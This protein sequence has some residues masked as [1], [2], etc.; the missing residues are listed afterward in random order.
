MAT[1]GVGFATC[2]ICLDEYREPRILPCGHSYCTNCLK[3]FI[4][5]GNFH[6]PECRGDI[7]NRPIDVFPVNYGLVSAISA[8]K[9]VADDKVLFRNNCPTHTLP[10]EFFCR[11]QK[12]SLSICKECWTK[13][14]SHHIVVPV[15]LEEL[16]SK[17]ENPFAKN[18]KVLMS[19]Q[20]SEQDLLSRLTKLSAICDP[21]K[22][23]T[24]DLVEYH[25]EKTVSTDNFSANELL[26]YKHEM[27]GK[28]GRKQQDLEMIKNEIESLRTM[29]LTAEQRLNELVAF[30]GRDS[31]SGQSER[32]SDI[33]IKPKQLEVNTRKLTCV[34]EVIRV[35]GKKL[36]TIAIN[37]L[38][39]FDTAFDQTSQQIFICQD[40]KIQAVD[41]RLRPQIWFKVKADE[42]IGITVS[43]NGTLFASYHIGDL[44]IT[45]AVDKTNGRI[46]R[47]IHSD[48]NSFCGLSTSNNRLAII[49][50]TS[51][52]T[53]QV[54]IF[55]NE[56]FTKTFCLK[57]E[58]IYNFRIISHDF[59]LYWQKIDD[60]IQLVVKNIE[61]LDSE[62]K[63]IHLFGAERRHFHFS[64]WVPKSPNSGYL[65]I[66]FL[67][68]LADEA[69]VFEVDLENV[70]DNAT[71]RPLNIPLII[72]ESDDCIAFLSAV[73]DYSVLCLTRR[74]NSKGELA[75]LKL[76]FESREN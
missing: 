8:S 71:L 73:A 51:R 39:C 62:N 52:S 14:H 24:E 29:T 31:T 37:R 63:I 53:V 50:R 75:L 19:F 49:H 15:E 36:A 48:S 21:L 38:F 76:E 30:I 9:E 64:I 47:N 12:C 7:P 65:F 6:C 58:T 66:S 68:S 25:L 60:R 34:R 43:G 35:D 3:T 13:S 54:F 45:S 27:L 42:L 41:F 67:T 23:K 72:K 74:R 61:N 32:K 44:R 17:I 2:S 70:G 4:A 59:F 56:K 16:Q 33:T 20:S 28:C 57:G 18:T 22:L 1:G 5:G 10:E 55:D 69:M 26:S 46:L 40:K 11:G